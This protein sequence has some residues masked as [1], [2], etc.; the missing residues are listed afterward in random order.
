MKHKISALIAGTVLLITGSNFA[1]QPN[2]SAANSSIRIGSR[3]TCRDIRALRKYSNSFT[4][5]YDPPHNTRRGAKKGHFDIN[6]T[7]D[8][9]D[10]LALAKKNPQTF[11]KFRFGT[12]EVQ[13]KVGKSR[14]KYEVKR[15]GKDLGR[16]RLRRAKSMTKVNA[17]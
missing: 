5:Y 17:C 8:K 9:N 14:I 12:T 3:V 6:V 13:K 16:Y 2:A 15:Y 11:S 1:Y 4:V 7:L 10:Y